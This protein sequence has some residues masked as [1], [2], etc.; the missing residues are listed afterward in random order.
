MKLDYTK[1]A[2]AILLAL[3]ISSIVT[4]SIALA[5]AKYWQPTSGNNWNTAANWSPSGVP[6]S[7]NTVYFDSAYSTANCNINANIDVN[8]FIINS[9]YT[10]TITQGASNTIAIRTIGYSQA[11][12]VFN[13]SSAN[14]DTT[15]FTLTGGT[16]N[17]TSGTLQVAP[18]ID[19]RNIQGIRA[20][21]SGGT[22]NH[23]SGTLV[24]M[25]RCFVGGAL[26]LQ[27]SANSPVTF[28]NLELGEIE[29]TNNCR[30][31]W[32]IVGTVPSVTVDSTFTLNGGRDLGGISFTSGTINAKGNISVG[33]RTGCAFGCPTAGT[34]ELNGTGDQTY[35]SNAGYLP[36]LKINKSQGSVSPA[37]GTTALTVDSLILESGTFNA[38]SGNFTVNAR[39]IFANY[40]P[41]IYNGGVF[42]QPSGTFVLSAAVTNGQSRTHEIEL[43][44]PLNVNNFLNT[45]DANSIPAAS[46][47]LIGTSATIVAE[48]DFTHGPGDIRNGTIEVRG[49]TNIAEAWSSTYALRFTGNRNQTITNTQWAGVNSTGNWTIDKTGGSLQLLKS[50]ILGGASGPNQKVT[51]VNGT[52]DLASNQLY[53]NNT[54]GGVEFLAGG[55][56][57]MAVTVASQGVVGNILVNG[58]VTG[59]SN[60]D[61]VV[62]IPGPTWTKNNTLISTN[63]S[64]GSN[65][66]KSVTLPANPTG[67][68]TYTA[69]S[70]RN[71]TLVLDG[72]PAG[73]KTWLPTSGNLWSEPN[74]WSPSGVPTSSDIAYFDGA[75]STQN[76]TIDVSAN[77]AGFRIASNYTG[78]ITQN[79]TALLVVGT[80]GFRQ[81]GGTFQGS[82]AEIEVNNFTLISGTFRAPSSTMT[83]LSTVEADKTVFT[84]SGGTFT[85]SSGTLRFRTSPSSDQTR[86]LTISLASTLTVNNLIYE[87]GFQQSASDGDRAWTLAGASGRI[88]ALGDLTIRRSPDFTPLA[89]QSS[90]P[91]ANGGT[92]EVR[93]NLNI[94]PGTYGGTT[95]LLL[96]STTNQIYSFAGAISPPIQINKTSGTV[97]PHASTSDLTTR[98]L[99]LSN[100]T[101]TAPGGTLLILPILTTNTTV[102]TFTAGTFNHSNGTVKFGNESAVGGNNTYTISLPSALTLNNL[103]FETG[104]SSLAGELDRTWNLSGANSTVI[105]DG[106]LT[107]QRNTNFT[108]EATQT[109]RAIISGGGI[110]LRGNYNIGTG[111]NGGTTTMRFSGSRRQTVTH[112]GGSP[113]IGNWTIDK[114]SESVMLGSNITFGGSS[115]RIVVTNGRLDIQDKTLTTSAAGAGIDFQAGGAPQLAL[116]VNNSSTAGRISATGSVTGI[117]NADMIIDV[118]GA[119]SAGP[120]TL[121]SNNTSFGS[122]TFKTVSFTSGITGQ[123]TYTANSGRN[124]T[125]TTLWTPTAT[126]TVTPTNTQTSTPTDTPTTTPTETPTNTPTITPSTTPTSTPTDTPTSTPTNTPTATPTATP[127]RGGPQGASLSNERLLNYDTNTGVME[128]EF[129]LSWNYSWRLGTPPNNWDA[130]WVF[131]K[132]RAN[133]GE[134]K[135]ASLMDT[136]HTAPAGAAISIGLVDSNAPFNIDT[137]PGVGAM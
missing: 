60:A 6:T 12:G 85:H 76:C 42:N 110:N 1:C 39:E 2:L 14:I 58:A 119:P 25:S 67:S 31:D 79:S 88:I 75:F 78:T 10:G 51:V 5:Q 37:A 8:G 34:I 114:T 57:S 86:A 130:M 97:S 107:I 122:S 26:T 73:A 95:T 116:L 98:A 77:V 38:P 32:Q 56:P 113:P 108:P 128:L 127:T 16:F 44:Q 13:G 124:V 30:G 66:F 87:A 54:G 115:Q 47:S 68:V 33:P 70:G 80:T 121:I 63:T 50:L 135:H 3:F 18:R 43:N 27:L 105:V 64:F 62:S 131:M 82:A 109:A 101:F 17:S 89:D 22:F 104:T 125:L 29:G 45:R 53:V 19:Q 103:I 102:F 92:I 99:T 137:N 81:E 126:P 83:V 61:L 90:R 71:V 21:F 123:L 133:A 40:R 117:S 52:L 4:P 100:G 91:I 55:T 112:S 9:G 41:V 49:N 20:S 72:T 65:Q 84:F 74:N 136:G 93:G 106:D 129:D 120:F 48:N 15:S 111:A 35:S 69:N 36:V 24:M 11:D 96:N 46:W 59:I 23:N 132:F 134:W 94:G 28:N 7:A 118:P